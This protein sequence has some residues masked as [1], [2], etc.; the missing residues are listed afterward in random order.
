MY[1][2]FNILKLTNVERDKLD[3][4][5]EKNPDKGFPNVYY[6]TDFCPDMGYMIIATYDEPKQT[7]MFG[8]F[9]FGDYIDLTDYDNRI[10]TF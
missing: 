4:F 5:I 2:K 1:Q 6:T 9:D 8:K 7:S 3:K 10:N